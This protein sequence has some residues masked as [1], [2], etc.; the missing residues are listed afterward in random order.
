MKS[1]PRFGDQTRTA[2]LGLGLFVLRP[3]L[4]RPFLL[5]LATAFSNLRLGSPLPLAFVGLRQFESIFSDP[6]FLHAL[7]NN[8]IFALTVVPLQT[9]LALGLALLLD[10]GLRGTAIYRTLFFMPVVF[11][12]SLVAV[13]WV[14]IYAPGPAGGG[15]WGARCACGG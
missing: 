15:S 4:L 8:L 10:Q 9:A 6:G 14:L 7:A 5:A 11:P 3:F 1:V 12:M 13:V 2:L